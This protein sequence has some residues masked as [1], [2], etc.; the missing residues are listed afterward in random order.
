MNRSTRVASRL[1]SLLLL[2]ATAI[3][4]NPAEAQSS[5]SPSAYVY[6]SSSTRANQYEI[7]AYSAAS[8][9]SLSVIAGS[10]YAASVQYMAVNGKYLLGTDGIDISTFSL[11]S[12]GA[13]QQISVTNAQQMN[14]PPG[15]GGPVAIFFDHTGSTLY[16]EDFYGSGCANNSYQSFGVDSSSGMLSYVGA[17]AA[18]TPDFDVPLSFIGNNQYAYGASCYHFFASIF[19]FKRATSGTLTKLN[20]TP[21]L[22]TAPAGDFYCAY[23][24]AADPNSNVAISLQPMN[25]QS[26]L[27]AGPTQLAVYTAD[28]SG[29][30]TTTSTSANMPKTL[31]GNVT[32]LRMAPSG[33]LLAVAGTGG[34]Q[35]FHF[36]G[37]S[38][39]TRDTG[40]LTKAE[41][42]Q[43]YWDNANHLYALSRTTGKLFVFTITPTS[44]T[45]A[46][47]SPYAIHE[48]VNIIVQPKS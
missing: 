37:A 48:A 43:L 6:V 17:T 8:N 21:A 10:P 33:K 19:G 24:A 9:G 5:P 40:L 15:C 41:I 31:V 23:L 28:N 42:D 27:T 1:A 44:A 25:N 35:I 36:N 16:D 34:L 3:A 4:Q 39:I 18:V 14:I 45:Q 12:N 29:N 20:T 30:L 22:P 32:D 38:P 2:A 7:N 11:A 13:L 26:W 47:G 46:P